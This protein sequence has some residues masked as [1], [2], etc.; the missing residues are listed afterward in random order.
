MIITNTEEEIMKS[1]HNK[2]STL[3]WL[4]AVL[5]LS[6]VASYAQE[7]IAFQSS[8]DGDS[9]V[10][11]MN[12]DGSGQTRL[13]HSSGEDIN[14]DFSPDGRLVVTAGA[15]PDDPVRLDGTLRFL[16]GDGSTQSIRAAMRATVSTVGG[17]SAY[18]ITMG[19]F[20]LDD[21]TAVTTGQMTG[22]IVVG[23]G[24]PSSVSLVLS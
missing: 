12:T 14:A 20:E 24:S 21:G 6:T 8:R 16:G 4:G 5:I 3:I 11:V 19:R 23:L 2:L 1:I 22:S 17:V 15:T 18:A 7:R 9:E 10:Y 13:T